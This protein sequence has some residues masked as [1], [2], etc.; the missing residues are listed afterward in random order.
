MRKN[1]FEL[2]RFVK[3]KKYVPKISMGKIRINKLQNKFAIPVVLLIA[4]I[5]I[6]VSLVNASKD[7]SYAIKTLKKSCCYFK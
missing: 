2:N 7:R 1:K 3:G 5:L 6:A 4:I